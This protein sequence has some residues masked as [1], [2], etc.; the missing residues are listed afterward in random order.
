MDWLLSLTKE[1]TTWIFSGIGTTVITLVVGVFIHK[2]GKTSMTQ[3]SGKNSTNY[4]AK[5]NI[6]I[7]KRDDK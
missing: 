3:K 2:K 4:Q 1:D 7:G 6:V 5:G